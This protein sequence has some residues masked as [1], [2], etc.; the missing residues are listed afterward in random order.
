MTELRLP[1]ITSETIA[2]MDTQGNPPLKTFMTQWYSEINK[3]IT[4]WEKEFMCD[5]EPSDLEIKIRKEVMDAVKKLSS[6]LLKE[7]PNYNKETM[8]MVG[9]AEII[10]DRL[11]LLWGE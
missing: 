1:I 11:N 7:K 8:E 4:Q 9:Y 10:Q 5:L 3:A 2:A 6:E